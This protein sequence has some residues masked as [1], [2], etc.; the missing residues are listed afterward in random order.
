MIATSVEWGAVTRAQQADIDLRGC[1]VLVRGT[2]R[3]TRWRTVPLVSDAQRS[4]TKYGIRF[5][6]A[7]S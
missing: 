4:L 7:C 6:E 3:T 1:R 2:K 5:T